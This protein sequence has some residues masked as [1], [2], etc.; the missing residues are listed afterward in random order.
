VTLVCI[1]TIQ[2]QD[3]YYKPKCSHIDG[4]K[5][6]MT[7]RGNLYIILILFK[8]RGESASKNVGFEVF[9]AVTMKNAGFWDVAPCRSLC[10][11][12]CQRNISPPCSG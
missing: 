2:D 12:T 4:G 5:P 11:L 10:E 7:N 8:L 6:G 1:Y 3:N 9:T